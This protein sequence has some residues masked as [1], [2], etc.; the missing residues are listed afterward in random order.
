[1]SEAVTSQRLRRAIDARTMRRLLV[2]EARVHAMPDRDLRDLGD[3][4]LLH[5]PKDPEPFWNRLEAIRWPE[6]PDA[7]DTRLAEILVL[8]TSLTRQP[9]IWP[10][11][12][13]NSPDDLVARLESNGFRDMGMGC[14]MVLHDPDVSR[15][16]PRHAHGPSV[17]LERLSGL[18]DEA[19]ITA[20]AAVTPVLCDAFGVEDERR[21]GVEAETSASLA[22]PAFTHYL[23][24]VDGRPAAVARRATFEGAS[25]LSSIGT[26]TWARGRGLGELVTLAATGRRGRGR[27]RVDVSRGLRGQRARHHPLSPGR[28][29]DRR[30]ARAG[31]PARRVRPDALDAIEAAVTAARERVPTS[32]TPIGVGWAT[33]ELDRAARELG[34]A[35]AEAAADPALGAACRSAVLADGTVLVLLEP[36]TEGRLAGTLARLGEGPHVTWWTWDDEPVGSGVPVAVH[37][38]TPGPLGPARLQR[39]ERPD[40]RWRFLIERAAAT[41]N[42]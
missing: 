6:A 10:S 7:F 38:T 15:R 36:S 13:H 35:V 33:V 40:G 26:A 17:S 24:R 34:I 9:H 11:P 14:V 27:Q 32:A 3:A 20:M 2:H 12:A 16:G 19:A 31:P 21:P 18:R 8:F 37:P 41:I 5:D 23:A 25:Y 22:N 28:L 29:R 1:M 39:D 4:I 42:G 30:L